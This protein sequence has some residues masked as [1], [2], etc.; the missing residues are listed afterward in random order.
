[1]KALASALYDAQPEIKERI[2]TNLS[3]RAQESLKEE[4]ELTGKVQSAKVKQARQTLEELA[5][6]SNDL[7]DRIRT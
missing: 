4:I 6:R 3:R 1:M 5:F 7:A 2:L